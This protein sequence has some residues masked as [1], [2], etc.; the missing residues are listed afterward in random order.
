MQFCT[1]LAGYR[2][3]NQFVVDGSFPRETLTPVARVFIVEPNAA[4]RAG[5]VEILEAENYEVQVYGSLNQVVRA[6]A[7]T[8]CDVALVA[9]QSVGGLLSEE[10]RHDLAEY[11]RR[12]HLVIMI[13]QA[14]GRLLD[15][16]DLGGAQFLEK[17]FTGDELLR[18]VGEARSSRQGS[19]AGP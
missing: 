10:H 16:E 17:P 12:L 11:T 1:G 19:L 2:I 14:W 6:A 3:Y 7:D 13:P 4:L 9:W 8:A 5:V 15:A 18:C